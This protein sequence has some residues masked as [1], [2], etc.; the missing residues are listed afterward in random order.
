M[1]DIVLR[2]PG[3]GAGAA[4][5]YIYEQKINTFVITEVLHFASFRLLITF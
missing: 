5:K 2:V 1:C 4:E 3:R